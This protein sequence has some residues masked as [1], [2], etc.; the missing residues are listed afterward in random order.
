MA[1]GYAPLLIQM[2]ATA[3]FDFT[4]GDNAYLMSGYAFMRAF[5]LILLFP[6]IIDWGRKWY[7]LRRRSVA[8]DAKDVPAELPRRLAS[9]RRR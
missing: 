5:F 4:Q 8:M 9:L 6:R 2:Y 1:T 7:V 3:V